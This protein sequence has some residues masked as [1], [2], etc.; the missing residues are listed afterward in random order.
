MRVAGEFL[1]S[2][3]VLFAGARLQPGANGGKVQRM[4]SQSR[5][6]RVLF[7]MSMGDRI[8]VVVRGSAGFLRDLFVIA[9]SVHH[10]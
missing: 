4:L 3:P 8:G 5:I 10:R 9:H 7:P 1:E 2:A 6:L